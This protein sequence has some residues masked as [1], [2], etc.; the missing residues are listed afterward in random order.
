LA[1]VANWQIRNLVRYLYLELPHQKNALLFQLSEE[2]ENYMGSYLEG[3][4]REPFYVLPSSF[5]KGRH[6]VLARREDPESYPE[7]IKSQWREEGRQWI[8]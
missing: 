1:S 4:K 6:P 3:Y 8:T 7:E 5:P 2:A